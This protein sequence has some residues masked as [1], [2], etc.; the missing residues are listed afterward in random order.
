MDF[1]NLLKRTWDIV[2]NNKWLIL[3][4]ILVALG[5]GNG[6]GGGGGGGGGGQQAGEW[7]P[8]EVENLEDLTEEDIAAIIEEVMPFAMVG[9]AVAIPLCCLVVFIGVIVWAVS[10]VAAGGLVSAV[11]EI[12]TGVAA[13]VGQEYREGWDRSWQLFKR[14]W[15][16]G[17][18]KAWRLIGIGILPA[19]PGVVAFVV[20]AGLIGAFINVESM[21]ADGL[22]KLSAGSGLILTALMVWCIAGLVALALGLLQT[23]ADRACMLEDTN[24]FESYGRGWQVLRDNLGEVFILFLIRI[25]IGIALFIL[26]IVPSIVL[27]CLIC[28]GWIILLLI[29]GALEAYFSTMW[30]LAWRHWTR[31]GE[32]VIEQAPTV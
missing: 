26:L 28:I 27:A 4:G 16:A 6:N 15:R 5:S 3:L 2:W 31:R 11:D 8:A 19:I 23:F 25:G 13:S 20:G 29:N 22:G 30:T 21:M 14:A 24:V 17:W 10:R 1:G 12:E 9:A 18:Q 32:L 7:P